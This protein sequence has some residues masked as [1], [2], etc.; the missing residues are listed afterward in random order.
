MTFKRHAAS[1]VEVLKHRA[2]H[3]NEKLLFR[4]LRDGELHEDSMS[5]GMLDRKAQSL[6]AALARRARPGDRVLIVLQPG[7]RYIVALFACFFARL[8]A[9]PAFSPRPGRHSDA[10]S[11]ICQDCHAA[12]MLADFE[13]EHRSAVRAEFDGAL[14]RVQRLVVDDDLCSGND[15]WDGALPGT[16]SLALLQY[17]SGSTGHPKGV[18]ITHG[19]IID[20]L[21]AAVQR[22]SIG[23]HSRGVT[24]LPPF[25]DMGLIAGTLQPVYSD[26]STVVLSPVHAMQRPMRWLKA[27]H[28]T[29]ATIS[30]GPPFAF[31]NCLMSIDETQRRELDLTTWDCA[32]VGAEP[33]RFDVL[34]RFARAFAPCGFRPTSFAP[35]YGLAEATLMVTG[36]A[37]GKGPIQGAAERGAGSAR[38][39]CGHAIAGHEVTIVEPQQR[40]PCADGQEGEIWVR[41][42]SIATGYW[43]KPVESE[44]VFAAYLADGRGPY[45][46]T[47]DLG[48]VNGGELTV[49]GRLKELVIVS[50]RN[51]HPEDIEATT[52]AITHDRLRHS[53]HAAFAAEIDGSER[54]VVAVE[55]RT[56]PKRICDEIPAIRAAISAAVVRSHGVSVHEV[57]FV[58]PG[59]MPRTSSG[60]IR[61]HLCR[62][63]FLSARD[64]IGMGKWS[65]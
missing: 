35:C 1:I 22:F 19:N 24:W 48:I 57:V 62:S 36:R 33:I 2:H 14:G 41:G 45:L 39:T 11:A 5:Y 34:E 61:R 40:V 7:L 31:E 52:C 18:M 4:Y 51:L 6:A 55:L 13:P 56:H 47:G 29:A 44:A 50:G 10:I 65:L 27:I 20:N 3:Q 59:E 26:C 58:G 23:S 43:K 15:A 8:V 9:V 49:T 46:R 54:L 30:G 63:Q 37:S 21:E 42:P 60:K 16:D 53:A 64:S 17:T 12:V 32:F 25:H 38:V 28:R